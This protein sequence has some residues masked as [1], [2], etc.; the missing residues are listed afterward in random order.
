M[1]NRKDNQENE[2]AAQGQ[3]EV[4]DSKHARPDQKGPQAHAE[5]Q[6]GDKT[7]ARFIEQLHEG[8]HRESREDRLE[9]DRNDNACAGGRRLVEDREQHDEAEKNSEHTQ[10]FVEHQLGRDEGP[11][12]NSGDLHGTLG[13][14]ESR[15]DDKPI[16]N[17][18]LR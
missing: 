14:R 9:R 6:H 17:R 7:H 1:A 18:G 5:G 15:A 16:D 8:E 2:P 3:E 4:R 10:R 13:H 12:D 11:S